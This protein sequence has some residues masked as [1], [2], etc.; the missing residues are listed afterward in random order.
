LQFVFAPTG[1][2]NLGAFARESERHGAADAGAAAGNQR[3]AAC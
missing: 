3:Y 2:G 1:D